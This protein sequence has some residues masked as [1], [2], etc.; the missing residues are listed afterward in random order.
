MVAAHPDDPDFGFAGTA[1]T[2]ARAGHAVH[3]LMCT[4]GDAGSDDPAQSPSELMRIREAEQAAAGPP[5]A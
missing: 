5:W 1:A 4:S 2:L 3:Y